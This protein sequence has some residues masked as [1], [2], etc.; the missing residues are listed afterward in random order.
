MPR[1]F[2]VTYV[3]LVIYFNRKASVHQWYQRKKKRE[4]MGVCML[5][6]GVISISAF[7]YKKLYTDIH[8]FH[9]W[10]YV[11]VIVSCTFLI[12][13][14]LVCSVYVCIGVCNQSQIHI[15]STCL[16]IDTKGQSLE[17]SLVVLFFT[18]LVLFCLRALSGQVGVPCRY[19]WS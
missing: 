13:S 5:C 3:I 15:C 18:V 2:L 1:T 11:K 19:Q 17:S 6:F 7:I 16:I 8:T 12:P 4:G 10:N 14:Y 9:C